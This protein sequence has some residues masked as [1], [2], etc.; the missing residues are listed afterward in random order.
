LVGEGADLSASDHDRTECDALADKR[1]AE[2]RSM[3][4]SAADLLSSWEFVRR[5]EVLDVDDPLRADGA[6]ADGA[7]NRLAIAYRSADRPFLSVNH[8]LGAIEEEEHRVF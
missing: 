7:F 8:H 1:H 4:K 6:A 5:C 3:A 2:D